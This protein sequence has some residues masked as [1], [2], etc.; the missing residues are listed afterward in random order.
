[1]SAITEVE[2]LTK[3]LLAAHEFAKGQPLLRA[4]RVGV[5]TEMMAPP[6]PPCRGSRR[7][8]WTPSPHASPP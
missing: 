4:L 7:E 8:L 1:M 3:W 5:A 2:Q 6:R